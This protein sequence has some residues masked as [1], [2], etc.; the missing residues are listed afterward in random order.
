SQG[1]IIH[2]YNGKKCRSGQLGTFKRSYDNNFPC[3]DIPINAQSAIVELEKSDGDT[4]HLA[5][6][7]GQC[8]WRGLYAS[9]D[10]GCLDIATSRGNARSY[11]VIDDSHNP[12]RR[13]VNETAE[14]ETVQ[15][16]PIKLERERRAVAA[17]Q[18]SQEAARKEAGIS[19]EKATGSLSPIF[20]PE[21]L[22]EGG[23][24]HGMV[25]DAFGETYKWQQVALGVSIG[26]PVDEWD[27]KVHTESNQF[28]AYGDGYSDALSKRHE[29]RSCQ[30]SEPGS[31]S[32]LSLLQER[33]L[34]RR[35]DWSKCRA[36]LT[37][38][39]TFGSAAWIRL[40]D[41]WPQIVDCAKR[42]TPSR[43]T[44]HDFL[45]NHPV[46][47]EVVKLAAGG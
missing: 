26:I 45:A 21:A 25:K 1:F 13:N 6:F 11:H 46:T 18:A 37:C 20:N 22:N 7:E 3:F 8:D 17:W 33:S 34:E 30:S 15:A 23:F 29:G 32:A 24:G 38:G 4:H 35:W 43:Q 28:V 47:C 41:T 5:F 12:G 10:S 40:R 2:F 16:E 31:C 44:I 36:A 27:D 39:R 42:V 9:V 19:V 14:L